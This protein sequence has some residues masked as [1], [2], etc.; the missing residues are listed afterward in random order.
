VDREEVGAMIA[1]I[2]MEHGPDGH[3]DGYE[4]ITDYVMTLLDGTA[5]QLAQ[6]K[7]HAAMQASAIRNAAHLIRDFMSQSD[8]EQLWRALENLK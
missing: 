6:C 8:M 1:E 5:L 7:H 2:L 3:V 4:I